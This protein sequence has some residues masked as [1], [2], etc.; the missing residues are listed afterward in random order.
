MPCRKA[1]SLPPRTA[2][3]RSNK[4][5]DLAL[6]QSTSP[7]LQDSQSHVLHRALQRSHID[8]PSGGQSVL[9]S[10]ASVGCQLTDACLMHARPARTVGARMKGF[11]NSPC[12][13]PFTLIK[14]SA[15]AGGG[16]RR[17]S[18]APAGSRLSVAR[19]PRGE[20]LRL[21]ERRDPSGGTVGSGPGR[22][23]CLGVSGGVNKALPALFRVKILRALFVSSACVRKSSTS[24]YCRPTPWLVVREGWHRARQTL[25]R[26]PS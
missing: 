5:R 10:R 11:E 25:C 20:V 9:N 3:F 4:P 26:Y 7:A 16:F 2:L 17:P 15:V 6:G 12:L 19:Y 1:L 21:P 24:I 18:K 13:T 23:P 8:P 22:G 14:Q